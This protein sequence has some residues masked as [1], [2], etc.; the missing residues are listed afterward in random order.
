MRAKARYLIS[1]LLIELYRWE[2]LDLCVFQLVHCGIHL[3]DD[4]GVV[5]L[6]LFS[7]LVIDR[8]QLLAMPTPWGIELHKHILILVECYL[9]KVGSHQDLKDRHISKGEETVTYP[10]LTKGDRKPNAPYE[11]K[12]K[13]LQLI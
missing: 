6:V 11:I 3:A 12:W 1:V 10:G 5:V 8:S 7:K 4:H 2:G 13:S 9:I